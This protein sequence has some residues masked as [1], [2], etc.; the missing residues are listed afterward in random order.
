MQPGCKKRFTRHPVVLRLTAAT[1]LVYE[2]VTNSGALLGAL[3]MFGPQRAHST[4]QTMKI[5]NSL[6]ALK[7]RH[8]DNQLVRRKGRMYVINKT[9]PRYKARQG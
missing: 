9:A 2:P 3:F 8:R 7:G 5:K 4:G 1:L 6:K